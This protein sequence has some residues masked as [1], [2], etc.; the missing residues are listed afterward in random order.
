MV[1]GVLK[2]MNAATRL[3]ELEKV[4]RA[5]TAELSCH[6]NPRRRR[7]ITRRLKATVAEM[8]GLNSWKKGTR[9]ALEV[10]G[11]ERTAGMAGRRNSV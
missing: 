4:F 1:L 8:E 5:D 7:I 11:T 9:G 3:D 10:R 2:T 6:I